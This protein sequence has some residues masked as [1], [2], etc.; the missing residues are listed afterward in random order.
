MDGT[1]DVKNA[2]IIHGN[3][4][5]IKGADN[6]EI[7]KQIIRKQYGKTEH[8]I[9]ISRRLRHSG[10]VCARYGWVR[11]VY[12]PIWSSLWE[13]PA[14]ALEPAKPNFTERGVLSAKGLRVVVKWC[15]HRQRE[16]K[17]RAFGEWACVHTAKRG[18]FDKSGCGSKAVRASVKRV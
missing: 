10:I 7:E 5:E 16:C 15:D 17:G 11:V 9:D 2:E 6:T 13:R 8:V 18:G 12:A 1:V 14:L 3:N 4:A